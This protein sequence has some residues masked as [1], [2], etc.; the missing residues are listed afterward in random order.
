VVRMEGNV[1]P[2][3]KRLGFQGKNYA[4]K[5]RGRGV[6]EEGKK[7]ESEGM[8]LGG[9]RRRVEKSWGKKK[10]WNQGVSG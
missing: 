3:K 8:G 10:R 5:R 1:N 7:K 2:E 9:A 6:S 4:N